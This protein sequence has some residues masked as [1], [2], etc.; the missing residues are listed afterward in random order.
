MEEKDIAMKWKLKGHKRGRGVAAAQGRLERCESVLNKYGINFP[1][2]RFGTINIEL[3]KEFITPQPKGKIIF[4]SRSEILKADIVTPVKEN[5]IL[6]PVTEINGMKIEGYIYR[7]ETNYWGNGYVELITKDLTNVIDLSEG[8]EIKLT[9]TDGI[10]KK[11]YLFIRFSIATL[12]FIGLYSVLFQHTIIKHEPKLYFIGFII[13]YLII[14]QVY[15]EQIIG[16]LW[17]YL[18]ETRESQ[19]LT[20]TL[21][22]IDQIIYMSSFALGQYSPIGVWLG[23]KVASRLVGVSKIEGESARKDEGQ[24]RNVY[25]IGNATTLALGILGGVFLKTLLNN[26]FPNL[27]PN[28]KNALGL[29][30]LNSH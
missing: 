8:V 7:T 20:A 18:G 12:L 10:M 24:R 22:I 13:V 14:A 25:L 5:W 27:L 30:C 1:P 26:N 28:V 23:I 4:I 9:A 2:F 3:D 16:D 6:I 11:I 19:K 29:I 21:G 15:I 17:E